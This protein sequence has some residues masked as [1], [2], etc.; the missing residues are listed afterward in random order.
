MFQMT[1]KLSLQCVIE[2]KFQKKFCLVGNK[3]Q[4]KM[5]YSFWSIFTSKFPEGSEFL[6]LGSI[7]GVRLKEEVTRQR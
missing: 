6:C 5:R 7:C 3:I 1:Q 2:C 4:F